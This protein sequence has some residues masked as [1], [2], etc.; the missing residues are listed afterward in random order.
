[1]TAPAELV[2]EVTEQ[3]IRLGEP[4]M[5]ARCPVAIACG[6]LFPAVAGRIIAGRH[7]LII[8]GVANPND[9]SLD[10]YYDLPEDARQLMRAFDLGEKVTPF[11]FTARLATS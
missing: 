11:T 5:S 9:A 4:C 7:L 2:I 8:P 3:D 10:A 6:R 1:M